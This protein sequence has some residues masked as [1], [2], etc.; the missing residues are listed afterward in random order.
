MID[1]DIEKRNRKIDLDKI[2]EDMFKEIGEINES[3][4]P[5]G[6]KTQAFKRAAE[7]VTRALYGKRAKN[8]RNGITHNTASKYLTKIRNQVTS[9][10]W[11]HHSLHVT[12]DRLGKK[13]PH[14]QHLIE[15]LQDQELEATRLAVKALKDKLLQVDR[16]KKAVDGIDINSTRYAS[17][18]NDTAKSFEAWKPELQRL[19]PVNKDDRAH[20]KEALFALLD[21]CGELFNDLEGIKID[22]E[23]MRWLVKDSFAAAVSSETSAF[24][25]SKKKGQTID[26][27]YPTIMARCE[28]LLSPV[29]PEVWNWEALATGI[30]LATGR[31]AIEVLVQGEFEKSG[32]HKLMFSGQAKERGGVDRENKFEIYSL[33]EAD[34][35]LAAIAMLRSYPKVTA[36]IDELDAGRHYQFNELVH[37]RTAAY[38]NDFMRDMMEAANI[39]TGIPNRSWVFKDTRAIYAAVCF[40]LFFDEDKRWAN[41]DQDMFFQTLLGHSDPKA[42]AHYKQFKILRAGQKWESI[43]ADEKDRLSEL[44]RFDSHEDIVNSK[45]LAKMHENVKKLIKQDPDIEIKQRTIKSNFG[46]NYATIRKYM[47]IVEEALSFETTLDT[48]LKR[49]VDSP[50]KPEPKPEKEKEQTKPETEEKPAEEKPIKP[51]EKPKFAAPKRLDNG[52]W[53]VAMNYRGLDFDFTVTAD[54]AMLAMHAAWK[55]YEFCASLPKKPM[56]NTI[57]KNGWWI[58]QVK[59]KGNVVL[60]HMGPGKKSEYVNAVLVDYNK[61]FAKYWQ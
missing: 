27:D 37:N 32:T 1:S 9:K 10:G 6:Q 23:I 42:Q 25:L 8:K 52:Y 47:A 58:A 38:L 53:L 28:F 21:E 17:M 61:R 16:L 14:C 45:A 13:Y 57:K 60:E 22:H 55:E 34:K 41:V 26:I 29:N 31:R 15:P 40:K 39:S 49:D 54:N 11:L 44:Q 46:G 3:D 59:H 20:Q 18:V 5:Q 48:I 12:L 43:V 35:V 33:V 56:I 2:I 51:E 24:A 19:K 36:M 4:K 50:E 30:A 7:K